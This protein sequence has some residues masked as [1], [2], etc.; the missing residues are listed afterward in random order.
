MSKNLRRIIENE[1][2]TR[3]TH[4]TVFSLGALTL[5]FSVLATAVKAF[6]G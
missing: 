6:G 4:W 2:L 5:T 1:R 3:A